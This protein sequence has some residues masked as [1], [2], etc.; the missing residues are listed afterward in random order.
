MSGVE[1]AVAGMVG[2][3]ALK[4]YGDIRKGQEEARSAEFEAQQ[5]AIQQETLRIASKQDETK[6]RNELTSSLE[7]IQAIRAGRGV[8]A[9]SPG[10]MAL[11]D[12]ITENAERDISTSKFNFAQKG[13]QA[14]LLETTSRERGKTSL[15]S[16]YLNAGAD[17][18]G[19]VSSYARITKFGY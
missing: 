15:L 5:L 9:A 11:F 12:A 19:G 8:G 4:A 16:G 3:T 17:I 2:G 10:G 14:R 7:T 13:E 1:I 6:R 18:A